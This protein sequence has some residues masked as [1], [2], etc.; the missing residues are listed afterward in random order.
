[1]IPQLQRNFDSSVSMFEDSVHPQASN[2][3]S[4]VAQSDHTMSPESSVGTPIGTPIL[5]PGN[6]YKMANMESHFPPSTAVLK[7]HALLTDEK[8]HVERLDVIRNKKAYIIDM[9]GVIYHVRNSKKRIKDEL[10]CVF[11]MLY[12]VPSCCQ[13]QKNL[14]NS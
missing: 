6:E 14:C 3:N 8:L 11:N 5:T 12:R 4:E 10:Y 2:A 13:E 1:M 7:D 9:D